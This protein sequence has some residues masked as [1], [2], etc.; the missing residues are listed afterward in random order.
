MPNAAS[1]ANLR[2]PWKPGEH[3][4]RTRRTVATDAAI[5]KARKLTM[6]AIEFCGRVLENEA[7]DVRHRIKA[8]EIILL[9]GMPKGDAH[10]RALEGIS[11]LKIEFV[12]ADGSLVSFQQDAPQA[13]LAPAPARESAPLIEHEV[14]DA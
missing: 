12:A 14:D 8:A 2:P 13:G 10:R 9:H 3:V 1:L 6:K 5:A 7:E 4:P 11:S